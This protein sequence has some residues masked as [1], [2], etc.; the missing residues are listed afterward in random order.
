MTAA[1]YKTALQEQM[2]EP[3]A[4]RIGTGDYVPPLVGCQP[5]V[6]DYGYP[7]CMLSVFYEPGPEHL[8]VYL[9][10]DAGDPEIV[11]YYDETHSCRLVG[12]G[13]AALTWRIV[14]T[15]LRIDDGVSA[16][17]RQVAQALN[18]SDVE[19]AAIDGHTYKHDELSDLSDILPPSRSV[20]ARRVFTGKTRDEA[21]RVKAFA[22]HMATGNAQ[23]AWGVL[24]L[25][26]WTFGSARKAVRTLLR[27]GSVPKHMTNALTHWLSLTKPDDHVG[28]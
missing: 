12:V 14:E 15:V 17:V 16:R 5:G 11:D 6:S 24:E 21:A 19:L 13:S 26:G 18:V 3:Q 23:A 25:G 10:W 22:A 7:P 4:I 28:Y 20:P 27:S 1:I 8:A 2:L 9:S